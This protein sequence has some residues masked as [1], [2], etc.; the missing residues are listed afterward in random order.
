MQMQNHQFQYQNHVRRIFFLCK[1]AQFC[2]LVFVLRKY[3][4]FLK[5]HLGFEVQR[6]RQKSYYKLEVEFFKSNTD[7]KILNLLWN[8]YW[9]NTLTASPLL[10][11]CTND[12][13]YLTSNVES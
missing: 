7:A 12:A 1:R 5:Y 2:F 10:A 13:N 3:I 4:Q 6:I 11:V 8:K 9:I